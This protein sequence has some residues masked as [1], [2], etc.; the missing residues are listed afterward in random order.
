MGEGR[1]VKGLLQPLQGFAAALLYASVV[2][3]NKK[4]TGVGTYEKTIV[5]LIASAVMLIPY[6]IL[7][8]HF[9]ATEFSPVSVLMLLIVGVV[10]TGVAYALYFGSMDHLRGQT[11]ALLSYIDP[12]TA[13]LLSA[14]VLRERMTAL[15]VVGTVLVLGS[16]IYSELGY[17][18][19]K[20]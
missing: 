5:Q 1:Q 2:V 18:W 6:L 9:A 4:V 8:E 19:R 12:V 14:L 13:I 11:V 16:T 10:H 17:G 20:T 3:L 15:G 7:T